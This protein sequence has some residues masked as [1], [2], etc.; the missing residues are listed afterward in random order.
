MDVDGSTSEKQ[1][2]CCKWQKF[3]TQNIVNV[4]NQ[5]VSY[6]FDYQDGTC[7]AALRIIFGK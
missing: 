7:L 2:I 4:W 3:V 6:M 5:L 1:R